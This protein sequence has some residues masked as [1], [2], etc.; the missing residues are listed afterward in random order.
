MRITKCD[1]CRKQIK[2]REVEIDISIGL[3]DRHSFCFSCGTSLLVFLK[4]H[5]LLKDKTETK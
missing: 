3:W 4:K 1:I 5:K 2:N